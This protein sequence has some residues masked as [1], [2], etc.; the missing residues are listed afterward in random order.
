MDRNDRLRSRG[1]RGGS[2]SRVDIERRRIDIDEHGACAE[3]LD[4]TGRG[5]ERV[6]RRD[7]LVASFDVE[8]HQREQECIGAGRHGNRVLDADE[9]TQFSLQIVDLRPHDEPLAVAHACHRR[10]EVVAQRSILGVEVEQG[11]RHC[12]YS[13]SPARCLPVPARGCTACATRIRVRRARP[14]AAQHIIDAT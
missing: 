4:R 3:P 7:D 2:L 12:R 9:R 10:E 11:N 6:G 5:E 13:I 1:D 8:R 14:G